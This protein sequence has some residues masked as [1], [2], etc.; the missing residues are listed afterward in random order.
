MR[1]LRLDVTHALRGLRTAPGFT[2]AA[3]LSLTIGIGATTAIF[4]VVSALLLRPLPYPDARR[5]VILWNTSPGLGITEDWFST[6]QY[7]DVTSA[8]SSFEDVAI[9]IGYTPALT[10]GGEPERVSTLRASSNLLP[11]FGAR[12]ELGRLLVPGDNE[13]GAAGVAVLSHGTWQRRYGGDPAVIGRPILLN[14]IPHEVVGVLPRSFDIPR[15]VVPT[16]YGGEHAEIFVPLPLG[17]EAAQ[18]RNREDFNI[19][20]RLKP[21]ASIEQARAELASVTARLRREHPDAYPPNGGLTFVALPL[22]EQVV[23][24]VRQSLTVLGVAVGLVLL[25]ACANV[26]NLLLSRGLARHKELAVRAALG[27]GRARLARQLLTESAVLA[28]GGGALGIAAA[29]AGLQAIRALGAASIPRLHEISIDGRVLGFTVVVSLVSA[30]LSGLVPA[31]RLSRV[32]LHEALSEGGRGSSGVGAFWHRGR[33]TRRV[34]VVVEIALAVVVLAGAA[35]LV[36]SFQHLKHVPTG[37]N[38][39]HVLTFELAMTGRRYGTPEAVLETYKELWERLRRLP[40]VGAVGGTSALPLSNMMS[41]GPITVEGR[42]PAAGEKF[43]NADQR[44]VAAD[45][46]RAMEIP[47]VRG[48]LFT[49]AD[50]RSAPRVVVVDEHM[51][52]QL[53]PGADPVG[54]RIRTGGFDATADAPW[55]TVVGVVGRVKH[56][57]LDSDPRIAFYLPH[58]QAPTRVLN[59]VVRS[60]TDPAGVAAAVRRELRQVDPDLPLHGVRT[61]ASRIDRWLAPRR[62]AVLL[63]AAFACAAL[64]LAGTGVYGVMAYLVAQGTRDLGIRMAFG[65]SPGS[66]LSLVLGQGLAMGIVGVATGLMASA[67]LTRFMRSLLF[68]VRPLD[69]LALAAAAGTLL[70]LVL[71]AAGVPARR[72]T[73]VDPA[74]SLRTE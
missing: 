5:L 73:R 12:A 31:L 1:S 41:W 18:T 43:V 52:D 28:A 27:A 69:P 66:I 58:A 42:V 30:V 7:F 20:A 10:G 19:V 37:F 49:E 6:A 25:I 53:W 60:A 35:L 50:Q 59:V 36:R 24:R 13:P 16:L 74:T 8:V 4:S 23:G 21:G 11:M 26:A 17:A 34:L 51:A 15:E 68:G 54:K 9:V 71:L 2:T 32:D 65:A 46:F 57:G 40:G 67:V 48:R 64:L 61:M 56:D 47:L 33:H 62:F 38:P 70:G 14:D 45:Y 39:D 29:V 72:A 44:V 63:L 3:L 22:H 55:M